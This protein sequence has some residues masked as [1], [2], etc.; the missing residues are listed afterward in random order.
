MNLVSNSL[1]RD[2]LGFEDMADINTAIS[3]VLP[4]VTAS[5][6]V[7][8]DTRFALSTAE[9]V[10]Y[11]PPHKAPDQGHVETKLRL[12]NGYLI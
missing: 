4:A 1:I 2:A 8:L 11:V 9:D 12:R 7:A 10:F 3:S 6:E 5:L